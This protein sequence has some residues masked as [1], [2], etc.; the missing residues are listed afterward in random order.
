ML[1][2]KKLSALKWFWA[3]RQRTEMMDLGAGSLEGKRASFTSLDPD[4]FLG[5]RVRMR[6]KKTPA[7]GTSG[8]CLT[9]AAFP[10]QR[11]HLGEGM[12]KTEQG[13]VFPFTSGCC[14]ALQRWASAVC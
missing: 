11:D 3:Q 10:V 12:R 7:Q 1:S 13:L 4:R 14:R 6:L 2:I 8:L 9:S 5:F